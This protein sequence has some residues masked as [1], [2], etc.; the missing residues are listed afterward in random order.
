MRNLLADLLDKSGKTAEAVIEWGAAA[1]TYQQDGFYPRAIGLW[2]KVI[3]RNPSDPEPRLRIAELHQQQG[4]VAEAASQYIEAADLAQKAVRLADAA[5]A[6][7]KAL[8]LA[9]DHVDARCGRRR[10]TEVCW[11]L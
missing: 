4:H 7:Q 2:R 6:L 10:G 9:P 11:T 3:R 8:E 5:K 1:A